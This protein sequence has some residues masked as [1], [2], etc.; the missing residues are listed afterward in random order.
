MGKLLTTIFAASLMTSAAAVA[1]PAPNRDAQPPAPM[2]SP[3]S[4]APDS[5]QSTMPNSP[6]DTT[7]MRQP[8]SA[9]LSDTQAK[10]WEDKDIYSADGKKVGDVARIIRDSSGMVTELQADVGGFLGIGE[11]RVRLMPNQFSLSGDRV[12]LSLNADQV[13]MLPKID[14]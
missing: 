9:A 11:T 8:Q 3:R 14:K 7:P 5:G 1:Q 10:A 4:T 2:D 13:K 6:R 12:A